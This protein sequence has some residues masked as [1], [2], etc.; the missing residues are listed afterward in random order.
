MSDPS[1]STAPAGVDPAATVPAAEHQAAVD[2][3]V[4]A[5]DAQVQARTAAEAKTADAQALLGVAEQLIADLRAQV[6]ESHSRERALQ[7]QIG[8]L[9]ARVAELQKAGVGAG[10]TFI[11]GRQMDVA[12]GDGT[13]RTVAE[14]DEVPEA[15]LWPH[16]KLWI[17]AGHILVRDR[18][19]T[20]KRRSHADPHSEPAPGELRAP[21]GVPVD[22]P[23]A[24][25]APT[26]PAAVPVETAAESTTAV[27]V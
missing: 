26:G 20:G 17:D 27:G 8:P 16:L 15:G 19:K 9:Q 6:A 7:D 12:V 10:T 4:A 1:A 23:P 22:A 18:A 5:L 21:Q 11:A 2:A 13:T 25:A 24:P 14:G 3:H